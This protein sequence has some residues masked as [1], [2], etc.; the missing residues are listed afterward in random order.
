MS[1]ASTIIAGMK[2]Q[3]SHIWKRRNDNYPWEQDRNCLHTGCR[4]SAEPGMVVGLAFCELHRKRAQRVLG[5]SA[6]QFY[7]QDDED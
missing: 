7:V 4:L 3:P 5:W 1:N 2:Q 6:K